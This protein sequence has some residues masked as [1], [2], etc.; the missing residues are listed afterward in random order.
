VKTAPQNRQQLTTE[1]M[2]L[3]GGNEFDRESNINPTVTV[4]SLVQKRKGSFV[5]FALY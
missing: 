1:K 2:C 5:A 3:H 4:R